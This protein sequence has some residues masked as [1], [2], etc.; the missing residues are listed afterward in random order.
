MLTDMSEA[1]VEPDNFALTQCYRVRATKDPLI[2][3]PALPGR[4]NV[5]RMPHRIY[6]ETQKSPAPRQMYK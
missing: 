5:E 4:R 6:T 2:V 3:R 1:L